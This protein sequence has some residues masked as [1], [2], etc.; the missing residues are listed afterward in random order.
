MAL[1]WLNIPSLSTRSLRLWKG[2]RVPSS[3]ATGLAVAGRTKAKAIKEAVPYMLGYEGECDGLRR[4]LHDFQRLMVGRLRRECRGFIYLSA[5]R[6]CRRRLKWESGGG[7]GLSKKS[8]ALPPT[9]SRGHVGKK[10]GSIMLWVPLL[11]GDI[12][13][14]QEVRRATVTDLCGIGRE[15]RYKPMRFI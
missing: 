2:M 12:P 6:P 4:I 7:C 1:A 9:T 8:K 10:C 5:T 14:T 11:C 3:A 13:C 15:L